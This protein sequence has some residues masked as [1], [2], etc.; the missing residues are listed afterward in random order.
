MEERG[1]LTTPGTPASPR[2]PGRNPKR[3]GEA[4]CGFVSVLIHE[5]PFFVFANCFFSNHAGGP[6]DRSRRSCRLEVPKTPRSTAGPKNGQA[7]PGRRTRER[8]R[9]RH[10]PVSRFLLRSGSS[11]RYNLLWASTKSSQ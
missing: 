1:T 5:H 9:K 11:D 8:R 2:A 10:R 6:L 7:G 3:V 4:Y